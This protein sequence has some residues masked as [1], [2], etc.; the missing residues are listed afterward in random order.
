MSKKHHILD[1]LSSFQFQFS[2]NQLKE[3]FRNSDS[4]TNANPLEANF[5]ETKRKLITENI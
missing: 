1:K 4:T 2:P 5:H 3:D